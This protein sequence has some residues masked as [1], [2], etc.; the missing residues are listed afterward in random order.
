MSRTPTDTP[1]QIASATDPLP[2]REQLRE[3]ALHL[4]VFVVA[5]PILFELAHWLRG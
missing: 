3:A 5:F 4:A 1:S 2:I